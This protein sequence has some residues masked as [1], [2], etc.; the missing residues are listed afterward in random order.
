M[1]LG[2]KIGLMALVVIV[3]IILL[4]DVI[5]GGVINSVGSRII[6][7]PVKVGS[8][9][10]SVFGQK[11]RIRNLRIDNPEGFPKGP[12]I[13]ITEVGLDYNVRSLMKGQLYFPYVNVNVKETNIIRN[14]DGKLNVDGLKVAQKKESAA[15]VGKSTAGKKNDI[16]LT[17][18]VLKLNIERTVYTDY[19]KSEKGVT[20]VFDVGLRDK[21]FKNIKSVQQLVSVVL[22]QGMAP[23]A[24][25]GAAIYTAANLLTTALFPPAAIGGA[26]YLLDRKLIKHE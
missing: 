1:T 22:I 24:I 26:L 9:S 16:S 19:T 23:A 4:K 12:L 17:I 13:D 11:I 25:K 6:G 10:W 20:R 3:A 7:A 21:T 5:I 2:K 18:D 8:F 14:K 15:P